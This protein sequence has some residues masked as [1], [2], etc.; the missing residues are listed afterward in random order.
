MKEMRRT[1]AALFLFG[2]SFGYLEAAVVT[3]L[4]DI[5]DP[6]RRQ[7]HPG[8]SPGELFPL[9]TPEQL[10]NSGAA[11]AKRLLIELGRE[12]ATLIMLGSTGL[13][14]S[15]RP[16][17]WVAASLIAF[18]V[19]DISFYVFLRM[20]IDWP[21]SLFTWDILFLLPVP[22]V[23]PVIAP[24]LVSLS[25]IGCGLVALRRPI[26]LHASHWMA[27]LTGGLVV[28]VAF[29]WDFRN[30]SAG[31]LPHPFNWP[32]FA[33]GELIGLAGFATAAYGPGLV[34]RATAVSRPGR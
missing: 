31:G 34:R 20:L 6:I 11:N 27:I 21:Q 4:R 29:C 3:Y 12:A 32:L 1:V 25:M 8:R 33:S 5:Y 17:E 23:G 9:I 28:V 2:I 26:S 16:H 22:W 14:V 7:V 15:R 13:A 19:W 10:R 24:I 18:G 30:T